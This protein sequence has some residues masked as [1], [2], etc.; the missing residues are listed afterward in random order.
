MGVATVYQKHR[1]MQNHED[2]VYSLTPARCWKV[3]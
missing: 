1:A 2:E 3:N